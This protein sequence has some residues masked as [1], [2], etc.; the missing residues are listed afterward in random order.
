MKKPVP[1]RCTE[2]PVFHRAGGCHQVVPPTI[3]TGPTPYMILGE[4]PGETEVTKRQVFVGQSGKYLRS[5]LDKAGIPQGQCIISNSVLC[6]PRP[7]PSS[8]IT[9]P[10]ASDATHCLPFSL[11]VLMQYRPKVVLTLGAVATKA[12]T[13][14]TKGISTIRGCPQKISIPQS[15][16]LYLAHSFAN[17]RKSSAPA[18]FPPLP[19]PGAKEKE[20][21]GYITWVKE[22]FGY[23]EDWMST[24]VVP[25]FHPAY[26]LRTGN[27]QCQDASYMMRD[28]LLAKD[29]AEGKVAERNDG[30]YRWLTT[31]KEWEEYV[32]ETIS[33]YE[34]G[35]ISVIALD[36][37]TSEEELKSVGLLRFHLPTRLLTIQIS[38][39]GGEGV[40]LKVNHKNSSIS[41]PTSMEIFRAS[42]Q[43]LLSKVPVTGQNVV[44]DHHVIR[45]RFGIEDF[46]VVGDTMLMAHWLSAG[47]GHTYNLDDLGDRYL[48]TGAH[49]T[50]AKQWRVRN[51]GRTFEDMPD[52]VALAYSAGDADVSLRLYFE[53]KGRLEKEG[54]WQ[55]YWD[56]YHGIHG[57]WKV[58]ADLEY[59]GMVVDRAT[60]DALNVEYPKRIGA[61]YREIQDSHFVKALV[62][63]KMEK[64]NQ[65][66]VAYNASLP[67]KTRKKPRTIYTY[68]EWVKEEENRFNPGS[69]QQVLFLWREV[70]KIPFD[71]IRDIEFSDT[72]PHCKDEYCKCKPRYVP[73]RPKTDEH[74]R[75]VLAKQF[76]IMSKFSRDRGDEASASHWEHAARINA[77]IG[78]HKE[79]DKLHSS[80]VHDIYPLVVDKEETPPGDRCF[81]LYKPFER[82]PSPWTLHPSYHMNGTETGR[83]SSSHP[84]GQN[85]PAYPVPLELNVKTPITSRWKGQGG[86][87]VQPDYSQIEIRV[88]VM[89]CKD[90]VLA[91]VLNS[92]VDFHRYVASMV[93]GVPEE[94]VTD[95]MRTPIK[96][97]T[98]GILYGQSAGTLAG[99]LGV[100]KP[101]AERLMRL[102]FS[103]MPSVARFVAQQHDQVKRFGYVETMFGRRRYLPKSRSMIESESAEALRAAVNTPVQS[104]ASDMCWTSYGR[105]WSTIRDLK[106]PAL[107]FSIVHDS[108]GFDVGPGR[109]F[110]VMELQYY[111]MVFKPYELWDWVIAKPQAE[112]SLGVNWGQMVKVKTHFSDGQMDHNLLTL[113]GHRKD[114]DLVIEAIKVGGQDVKV[115]EDVPHPNPKEA[116]AG[117]WKTKI[118]VD[119]PDPICLLEGKTLRI[120]DR[121][122]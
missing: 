76:P 27:S 89:R 32:D 75:N 114:V 63:A 8:P 98:F 97:V 118:H 69:W 86:L 111:Q 68:D 70:I 82:F 104:E 85:Y 36:L 74:N 119:R 109:F 62:T 40:S 53:L 48:A 22:T 47:L 2:C 56:L 83:L 105:S 4:A 42:L 43:R 99:D 60:L 110:D 101:E 29:L 18:N 38:K 102:F 16:R 46:K 17:S 77:L 49:K 96:R 88:M 3:P 78:K 64:W 92:D 112:F 37:E 90:T 57:G 71:R 14:V 10:T 121:K 108:Q 39:R 58:I 15:S 23:S 73:S 6:P 106:I 7:N 117:K 100:S 107:P 79:L 20:V 21:E 113:S 52:D 120:L 93:H 65:E 19:L 28:I 50:E 5:L 34:S 81:P 80:Y 116:E 33:E 51:P 25:T 45:C 95:E 67:E 24:P 55:G 35:K 103:K 59:N 44:F 30:N 1:K 84:N 115:L 31:L 11:L 72:C 26:I 87:L 41:D 12:L 54:R 94:A 13:G 61:V 91:D 9:T 66:A 122:V